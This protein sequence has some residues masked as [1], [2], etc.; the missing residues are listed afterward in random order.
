MEN[1]GFERRQAELCLTVYWNGTE[2]VVN[3]LIGRRDE[4]F[5][6]IVHGVEVTH[7]I[8]SLHLVF[9]AHFD[10][11]QNGLLHYI[12]IKLNICMLRTLFSYSHYLFL[13]T[14]HRG[15]FRVAPPPTS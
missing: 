2:Q 1:V 15:L 3:V 4:D 10:R 7:H 8:V 9:S 12:E 5:K 13:P 14:T 6:N 11:I